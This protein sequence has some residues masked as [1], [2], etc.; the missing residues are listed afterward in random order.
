MASDDVDVEVVDGLAA[1]LAVVD[2]HPVALGEALLLGDLACGEEEVAKE[3]RKG[4]V[5][6][7]TSS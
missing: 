3:L 4:K 5:T 1:L 7:Q 6:I 2:H